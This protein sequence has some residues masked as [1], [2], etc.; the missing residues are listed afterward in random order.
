MTVMRQVRQGRSLPLLCLGLV[1]ER[2]GDDGKARALVESPDHVQ[3]SHIQYLADDRHALGCVEN[4]L[5]LSALDKLQLD[6]FPILVELRD[7]PVV[8]PVF[9]VSVDVRDEVL[10]ARGIGQKALGSLEARDLEGCCNGG[11][12]HQQQKSGET[13]QRLSS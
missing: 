13:Q 10:L 3:V 11:S 9:G 1:R 5:A 8:V 6:Q 12:Y 2:D 7:E 4:S